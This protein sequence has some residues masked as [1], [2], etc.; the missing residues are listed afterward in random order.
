MSKIIHQ[1]YISDNNAQPSEYIISQMSRLRTLY[2]DYKYVLYDNQRCREEIQKAFGNNTVS[3]YDSLQSYAFRADFARYILLYVY[4]GYYY[5]VSLCPEEKIEFDVDAV[6]YEGTVSET[7]T[8]GY[9]LIE[10]NFMFFKHPK[11][12]NLFDLI[13]LTIRNIRFRNYGI[14][15]LDITGPIVLGRIP[16]SDVSFGS[17]RLISE[18]QKGSFFGETL[19]YK[20]K[21]K[22]YQADLAKLGCAGTNNYEKMWFDKIVFSEDIK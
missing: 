15:P 8:I 3:L 16:F 21:S 13:G 6:L 1:I 2:S 20:H 17:V 5:D 4:G 12:K 19:H 7:E 11:N 9:R 14:H 18:T 22:E 10:N